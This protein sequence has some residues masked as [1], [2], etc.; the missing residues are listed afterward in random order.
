MHESEG[1][2]IVDLVP[3][4]VRPGKLR[5]SYQQRQELQRYA[6]SLPERPT[7]EP[8]E[9]RGRFGIRRRSADQTRHESELRR[10]YWETRRLGYTIDAATALEHHGFRRGISAIA[11]EEELLGNAEPDSLTAALGSD[12]IVDSAERIRGTITA[13]QTHFRREVI[14]KQS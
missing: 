2:T 5:Q 7:A 6:S 9:E 10:I 11:S 13:V 14:D 8:G 1:Q 4:E 3:T 12:L